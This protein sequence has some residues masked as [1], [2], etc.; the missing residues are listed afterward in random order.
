M[1][2][3]LPFSVSALTWLLF[4]EVWSLESMLMVMGHS[5]NRSLNVS[6]CCWARI[7]VGTSRAT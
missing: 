2:S 5:E 1:I 7:V 6:K 4:F 3:A